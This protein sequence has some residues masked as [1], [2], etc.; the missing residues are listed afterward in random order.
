MINLMH[1][2]IDNNS[3]R[4]NTAVGGDGKLLIHKLNIHRVI[5]QVCSKVQL[6]ENCDTRL[7]LHLVNKD[8]TIYHLEALFC[9]A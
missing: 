1:Y 5:K 6:I 8:Y 7:L 3:Y 2:T 9:I 4:T